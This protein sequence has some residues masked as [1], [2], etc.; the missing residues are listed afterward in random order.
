[1]SKWFREHRS[2]YPD[3]WD[4]IA[5][6]IKELAG[7]R[8]EACGR[9]GEGRISL[10]VHH[11]DFQPANCA[12]E[13]LVALCSRDHLR[14]HGM[15]PQPATKAECIWRLRVRHEI[16]IG[17][18]CLPLRVGR[19]ALTSKPKAAVSRK[20]PVQ[21]IDSEQLSLDFPIEVVELDQLYLPWLIEEIVV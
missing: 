4:E 1:M 16:E 18:L 8:C 7:W 17:Q 5:N 15:R 14:A 21:P 6:R 13:N 19:V 2:E 9:P 12:D 10:G 3:N 20:L 11:L